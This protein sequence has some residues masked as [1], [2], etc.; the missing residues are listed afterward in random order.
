MTLDSFFVTFK[1]KVTVNDKSNNNQKLIES[2]L[3][4][5][6]NRIENFRDIYFYN[7]QEASSFNVFKKIIDS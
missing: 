4:M 5:Q 1:G 7:I 3:M 2:I 6:L